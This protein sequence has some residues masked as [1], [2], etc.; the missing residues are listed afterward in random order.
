VFQA[1]YTAGV[2]LPKPVAQCRYYHR[3]LNPKKLVDIGFSHL[4]GRMTIPRLTRLNKLPDKPQTPG[5]RQMQQ[6]DVKQV[7][8]L[9]QDYMEKFD[10]SPIYDEHEVAHWFLTRNNVVNSWV[11]AEAGAGGEEVVTDVVSFYTLPSTILNNPKHKKLNAAYS[12]L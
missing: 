3:S 9:F 4:Y 6:K 2:V 11:V 12:F 10:L 8:K 1:V 5:L 7:T